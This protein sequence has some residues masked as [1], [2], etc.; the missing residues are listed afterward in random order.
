MRNIKG[1]VLRIEK[2]SLNDGTGMRTVVFLKGCPCRCAWC[3]TPESQKLEREVYYMKQRCRMCGACV[4]K[5]PNGA[6]SV[7][8]EAGIL[9]DTSLC[10]NCFTCVDVCNYRAQNIYGKEMTVKE[11]MKEIEKDQIFYFYSQGGLTLSGG[12]IFCQTD[13]A[14]AILEACED[15]FIDTCAELDMLTTRENVERIIPKLNTIYIDAKHMD[16]EAHQK[17]TGASNRT[18]LE[19]IEL[20]DTICKPN[21]IHIRLPLIEGV[22]DSPENIQATADFCAKLKNCAE[23]EF[24]PY[25]RLGVH[26]YEQLQREYELADRKPMTRFDVYEKTKFLLDQKLPFKMRISALAI[27]DPAQGPLPVTEEELKA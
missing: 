18:I 2:I 22:N 25:H 3:S 7:S 4:V 8:E 16:D 26:A 10:N 24:L 19:N 17:W 21:S 5:C 23:L 6:L 11:V 9:R 20:A 27:Y 15:I 1:T 13:F 12:D 14:E